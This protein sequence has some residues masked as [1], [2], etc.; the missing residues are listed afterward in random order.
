MARQ[1]RMPPTAEPAAIPPIAPLL[2]PLLFPLEGVVVEVGVVEMGEVEGFDR[3]TAVDD[4]V[5]EEV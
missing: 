3:G 4:E 5:G 1:N 2:R